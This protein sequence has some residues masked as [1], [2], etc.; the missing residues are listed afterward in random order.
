LDG[1]DSVFIEAIM[2]LVA[3]TV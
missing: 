2:I 3:G 1:I